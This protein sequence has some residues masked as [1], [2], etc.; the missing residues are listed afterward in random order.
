MD[1]E[2][3]AQPV[4]SNEDPEPAKVEESLQL[5]SEMQSGEVETSKEQ[6]TGKTLLASE[7]C[8]RCCCLQGFFGGSFGISSLAKQI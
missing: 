6:V 4:S 2:D 5:D 1:A 8:E 7:Y 3:D